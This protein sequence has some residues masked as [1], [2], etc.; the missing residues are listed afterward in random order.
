MTPAPHQHNHWLN[1]FAWLTAFA[2]LFLISVGGMVTSKGAGMSVP[3]WPNSYGYNMFFFPPSQWIGGIFYEHT[4][5]LVASLVGFLTIIL[6]LWLYGTKSR[7]FLKW[8]G[9]LVAI[10]GAVVWAMAPIHW[11]GSKGQMTLNPGM[12]IAILVLGAIS[13][14]AGLVWPKC[15]P[16][17]PWLRRLGVFGLGLVIFQGLLGGL[18]VT[19]F[20]DQ[21]GIFHATLAQLFLVLVCAIALFTSLRWARL[22][23]QAK[24]VAD[25]YG[26]R[27]V[28]L[29]TTVLIL[30][31]LIIGATMRHQHAGLAVPDF[32]LAY[33]KIW[34]DTDEASVTAYNHNRLEVNATH[35]ITAFQIKVHMVHRLMALV[36]FVAVLM[37]WRRTRQMLGAGDGLS[38]LALAW[39]ILIVIQASLG[40]FTVWSG[41]SADIATAHV[42]VGATSLVTGVFLT[43]TAFKCLT[44]PAAAA[45]HETHRDFESA[46]IKSA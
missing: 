35:P 3:D 39:F 42:A 7:A 13:V 23:E 24:K 18:R 29:G 6:V 38:R 14:A 32:P 11:E 41:K 46:S 10:L 12:G 31:Q 36:I 4:H 17:A 25:T 26:L 44:K 45:S 8:A 27:W 30:G 43:L 15:A 33:G 2:T 28:L 21:I 9:G 5:R 22:Q 34:P 16:S 40:I 20:K 37:A 19:L 1:R